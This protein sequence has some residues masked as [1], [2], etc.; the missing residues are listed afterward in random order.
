MTYGV[1]ADSD[2]RCRA[3]A[4][5]V[6]IAV[7]DLSG[8]RADSYAARASGFAGAVVVRPPTFDSD[9]QGRAIGCWEVFS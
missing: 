8:G 4:H 6:I 9:T 1:E 7:G 5:S 2:R 3:D